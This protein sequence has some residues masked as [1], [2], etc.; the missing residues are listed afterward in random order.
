MELNSNKEKNIVFEIQLSGIT[1]KELNGY[2]R[3]LVDGIEYGFPADI[4]E[5][6][7]TVNIPNLKNIIHRPLRE[8][9]KIK[10]KLEVFGNDH[11]MLP[12]SDSVTI[13]SSVMIEAKIVEGDSSPS[14][15]KP[16]IKAS[17]STGKKVVESKKVSVPVKKLVPVK[18]TKEHFIKYMIE[19]GTKNP[20]IQE[21]I[22]DKCTSK[23]GN[24][25]KNLFQELY[26]YYNKGNK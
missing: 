26:S 14:S 4:T 23:V 16:M 17:L 10:S 1:T 6:S 22:L 13:K 8:G 7:I 5:S 24:D 19:N 9:E 15:K 2:F 12:W 21:I 3:M 18:I 25:P 20:K 11:Y